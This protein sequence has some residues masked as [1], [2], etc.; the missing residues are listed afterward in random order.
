MIT[1]LK[2]TEYM[3]I[4]HP[5]RTNKITDL[6]KLEMNGTEIKRAH[7]VESLG[8]I[9]DEKLSWNDCFMRL[10]GK[11]AAGLASIK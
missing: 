11:V 10:K 7:K 6:A 1:N 5:L 2:K 3:I 4:G 8:L 9:V